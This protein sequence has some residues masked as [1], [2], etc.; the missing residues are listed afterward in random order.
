[1]IKNNSKYKNRINYFLF[2]ILVPIL[3]SYIGF[4]AWQKVNFFE[5]F[6]GLLILAF[7]VA[8]IAMNSRLKSLNMSDNIVTKLSFISPLFPIVVLYLLFAPDYNFMSKIHK[9]PQKMKKF[10]IYLFAILFTL[11]VVLLSVYFEK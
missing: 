8:F 4:F 10:L 5:L 9:K 6:I 1:M 11:G 3:I 7:L 2:G